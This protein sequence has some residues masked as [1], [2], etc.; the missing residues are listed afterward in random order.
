MRCPKCGQ[1]EDKVLDSRETKNGAVIRRRRQCLGCQHRF[2]TYEQVQREGWWVIKRDGRREKFERNKIRDGIEKA[3]EKRPVSREQIDLEVEEI[4]E[5][6][7]KEYDREV[8]S[9]ALGEMVMKHLR[10]M[11]EVAY[12][13][14]ASVYRQFRDIREFADEIQN[15]ESKR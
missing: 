5:E 7:E 3:C 15:L 13:R 14:F 9:T 12:V 1:L 8:P 2:T 11:D 6:I 10:R 4:M